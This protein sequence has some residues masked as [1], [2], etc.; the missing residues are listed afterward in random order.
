MCEVS[1]ASL[2]HRFCACVRCISVLQKIAECKNAQ[3]AGML[4]DSADGAVLKKLQA[5]AREIDPSA[6]VQF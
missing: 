5:R 4:L 3:T 1:S 6:K 2:L